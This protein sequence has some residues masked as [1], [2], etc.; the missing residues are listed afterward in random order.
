MDLQIL[1]NK[2]DEISKINSDTWISL[3]DNRKKKELEF[4]DKDRDEDFI[5]NLSKTDFKKYRGN[6][7]F[8]AVT[9][10]SNTYVKEWIK[11]NSTGKIFL[12]YACGN[13]SNAIIAAKAGAI[14]AI[15]I[16][17]SPVSISNAK[18]AAEREGVSSNTY[19]LLADAENTRLP[20]NSIDVV[21][22]SGMLHHLDLSYAL[23]ELRR[24]MSKDGRLLAVEALNYNPIIKLYRK[25]TP[26]MRTEWE[27]NHIISRKEV[28]FASYFFD[29]KNVKFWHITS[30]FAAFI[31][32]LLPLFNFLDLFLTRIPGIRLMAWQFTF[33]LVIKRIYTGRPK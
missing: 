24:I 12:D 6:R 16:D 17:I 32:P 30:I 15:G 23:P 31:K 22:C 2:L 29:V 33:E 10:A 18:R 1:R 13:G 21:I 19:F 25:V 8:Y 4:H 5:K 20:E 26:D 27:K 9:N 11:I 7:K 28:K 14:L 3:L